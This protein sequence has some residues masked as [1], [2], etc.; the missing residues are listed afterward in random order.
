M[1]V[2]SNNRIVMLLSIIGRG[3]SKAYLDMLNSRN[4]KHHFQSVGY[5]TAPSEMMDIFGLGSNDKDV[6]FSLAPAHC[7]EALSE[8]MGRNDP[9]SR[10]HFGGLVTILPL[11]AMNRLSAELL[12]RGSQSAKEKGEEEMSN[13]RKYHL[14]VVTVNQGYADQVMQTARK[15]GATGGTVIRARLTNPEMEQF[16]D[17]DVQE[18]KEIVTILASSSISGRIMEDVNREWGL[19][20]E[21]KGMVC[22]LPVDSAFKV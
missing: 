2:G 14:I 12:M 4:I 18:E 20:S 16:G 15:A 13:D 17:V 7:A 1:T 8:E 5:G 19:R 6:I 22:A 21:A 3:K 10:K 9:D 11:S